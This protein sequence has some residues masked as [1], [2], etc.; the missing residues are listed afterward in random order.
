[1]ESL[2]MQKLWQTVRC[3]NGFYFKRCC[4]PRGYLATVSGNGCARGTPEPEPEQNGIPGFPYLAITIGL[5]LVL[6][7]RDR[8]HY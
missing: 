3:I 8:I 5:V 4:T 2:Q 1:M 6:I 7:L